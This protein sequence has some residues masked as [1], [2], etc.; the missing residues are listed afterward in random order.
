M[1]RAPVA[2]KRHEQDAVKEAFWGV[3]QTCH[4]L[5]AEYV[6]RVTNLLQIGRLGDAPAALQHVNI[7]I[8]EAQGSQPQ[9]YGVRA[10]LE[11]GK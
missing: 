6:R 1:R 10:D 2:E 4:L 9:D 11:L 5:L 7:N 8:E 3:N